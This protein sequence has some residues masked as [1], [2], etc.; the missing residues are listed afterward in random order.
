M[1]NWN[2]KI[3]LHM[4]TKFA[5][6]NILGQFAIDEYSVTNSNLNCLQILIPIHIHP[7]QLTS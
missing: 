1:K 4:V 2:Q 6:V 5:H 7:L 3:M